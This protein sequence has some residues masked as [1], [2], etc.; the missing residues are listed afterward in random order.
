[1]LKRLDN[2]R[3]ARAA[4][5]HWKQHD[6]TQWPIVR[7]LARSLRIRQQIFEDCSGDGLYQLTG[8]NVEDVRIGDLYVEATTPEVER[9]WCAYWLPLIRWSLYMR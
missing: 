5:R 3:I 6:M 4:Y 9:D 1:M 2:E 7:Q 8:V